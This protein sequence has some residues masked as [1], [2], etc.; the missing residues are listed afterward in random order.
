[1]AFAP[2]YQVIQPDAVGG[3][4]WGLARQMKAGLRRSIR[5]GQYVEAMKEA[6]F[7]K[8]AS[9]FVVPVVLKGYTQVRPWGK[10]GNVGWRGGAVPV[11]APHLSLG[12]RSAVL[13]CG[14]CDGDCFLHRRLG[15]RN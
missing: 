13:L 5:N 1:V 15:A 8:A 11:S 3:G 2:M 4:L 12:V 9:S 10:G 6:W 7:T 14:I